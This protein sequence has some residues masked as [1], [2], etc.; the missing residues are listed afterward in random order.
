MAPL[1]DELD[2]DTD[3]YYIGKVNVD[4]L[5]DLAMQYRVASIPTLLVFKNGE[6]VNR[7]SGLLNRE[8]VE[9]LL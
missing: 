5:T 4:V 9:A 3:E 7:E 6:C 8:E 1:L 2:Q